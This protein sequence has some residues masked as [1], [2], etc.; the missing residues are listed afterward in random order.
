M[1][2]DAAGLDG[3]DVGADRPDT[4]GG[5]EAVDDVDRGQVP[6]PVQEQDLHELPGAG[7]VAVGLSGRGP[8]RVVGAGERA[9]GGGLDQGGCAGQGAG[10]VGQDLQVVIQ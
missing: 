5:G 6:V 3:D 4:E 7:G 1:V 10:L 9:A 8:E 2:G